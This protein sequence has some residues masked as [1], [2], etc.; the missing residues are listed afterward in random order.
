MKRFFFYPHTWLT[1]LTVCTGLP[2]V[3]HDCCVFSDL[4]LHYFCYLGRMMKDA[5]EAR[6]KRLKYVQESE[7]DGKRERVI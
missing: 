7:C 4:F 3:A 6:S 5:N 2:N 1:Q